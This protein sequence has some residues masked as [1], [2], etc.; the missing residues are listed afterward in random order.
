MVAFLA[1][2]S[3]VVFLLLNLNPVMNLILSIP[4]IACTSTVACRC[5]VSLS[6]FARPDATET[7]GSTWTNGLGWWFKRNFAQKRGDKDKDKDRLGRVSSVQ[8]V[9]TVQDPD[10][11]EHGWMTTYDVPSTTAVLA[12]QPEDQRQEQE[13]SSTTGDADVDLPEIRYVLRPI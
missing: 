8:W 9:H 4:A 11:L 6:T 13:R 3:V 1:N 7:R 12:P 5:F 10:T 2:L